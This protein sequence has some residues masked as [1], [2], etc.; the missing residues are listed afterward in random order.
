MLVISS[1]EFRENQAMY[2][3][4]VDKKE[5]VIVQRGKRKGYV[6]VPADD[7]DL[8]FTPEVLKKIDKALEQAEKG[9][10]VTCKTYEES[11]KLLESL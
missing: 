6:I 7:T 10:G 4:L 3:D 8:Y 5:K 9:E 11:L 2:F 1:R